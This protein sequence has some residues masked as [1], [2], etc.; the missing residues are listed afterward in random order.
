MACSSL[1]VHNNFAF[2]PQTC[3]HAYRRSV[4][5]WLRMSWWELREL[6]MI[7]MQELL[8]F[9]STERPHPRAASSSNVGWKKPENAH[10]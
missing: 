5:A 3:M 1:P 4:L 2:F 8:F 7:I 10:T 6:S 9:K